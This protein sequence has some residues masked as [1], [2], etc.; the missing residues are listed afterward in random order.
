VS[1]ANFGPP[2]GEPS[3]PPSPP[4]PPASPTGG[5]PGWGAWPD[6]GGWYQAG[7]TAPAPPGN[8]PYPYGYA[9]YPY[10]A[11]PPPAAG[12]R[13]FV[14]AAVATGLIIALV[15]G[16]VGAGV[17]LALRPS[18]PAQPGSSQPGTT[19][20]GN[21][22]GGGGSGSGGALS[23]AQIAAAIDPA[24]VDIVNTVTNQQGTAEGTGVIL[25]SSGEVLTNNHVIEG[26][27]SLSVQIDG[28]GPTYSATVVGY[29]PVDDVAVIQIQNPPSH[30]TPA[31]FGDSSS[32][33]VGDP[34]VA[35]GNAL[36]RGGTPAVASGT[37]TALDQS[38]TAQ[39]GQLSENL[40]GLIETD[41][42]IVPGDSGGPLVDTSGKVVGMDTAGSDSGRQQG[43]A[44]QGY[45]IPTNA[46]RQIAGQIV[47]GQGGGSI[48]IGSHGPLMGVDVENAPAGDGAM[49]VDIVPNS[50]AQSA[51]IKAGD[52]INSLN[53]TTVTS[54][55]DLTQALFDLKAGDTVQVGLVTSSGQQ[56]SVSLTLGTGPPY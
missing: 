55:S 32:L 42:D 44:V 23:A 14:P 12:R 2:P 34:V 36:G 27:T 6:P 21:T 52:V 9:G 41:A 30:L 5:A 16:V 15:A 54:Q 4:A 11:Y 56:E 24:V 10:T 19:A 37:V 26:E 46:A 8:D 43:V 31:P 18:A 33:S 39:D 51:G 7:W 38:I 45:A 22:S 49:V 17:G 20:P 29:D 50:P 35:L 48:I 47:A 28:Q 25:S 40:S 3:G 13:R 53:G 1:D